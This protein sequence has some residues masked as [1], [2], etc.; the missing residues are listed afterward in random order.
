MRAETN[1]FASVSLPPVNGRVLAPTRNEAE[2]RGS[3][4]R[5]VLNWLEELRARGAR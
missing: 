1:V 3:E 2:T 5:V 4:Y